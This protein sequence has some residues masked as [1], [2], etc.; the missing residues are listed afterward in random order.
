MKT[1]STITALCLCGLGAAFA[2]SS[3]NYVIRPE[4]LDAG[5][6]RVTSAS[7]TIHGSAGMI[8]GISTVASP[9]EIVKAGYI[10]QFYDAVGLV[11]SAS[12]AL[13][14][15]GQTR[16]LSAV[17]VQDDTT[18]LA[19]NPAQVAWSV[20]SGP[21]SSISPSGLATAAV[22][23]QDTAACAQ[24]SFGGF[25]GSGSLTVLNSNPD[26]YGDYAS[27]GL[28]DNWQVQYFGT[29]PNADAGSTADPDHDGHSNLF[30]FT[31][32]LVPTDSASVFHLRIL[33]VPGQSKYR[34]IVFSPRLTG[35]T[36]TV[37]ARRNLTVGTWEPLTD[38]TENDSG[39]ERTVTD[40]NAGDLEKFYRVQINKP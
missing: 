6:R 28:D 14:N 5:G 7:Y 11:V 13:V 19:L 37:Q 3:A 34:A 15:E 32:G 12:P 24:G 23:Y 4:T 17:Q 40:L 39:D 10:A 36:Y 25:T 38:A 30:E 22:V 27:D 9:P 21:L 8:G 31:A 16:Q 2:G 1:F 35:R 20:L 33:G 18:L 29:P 26:D